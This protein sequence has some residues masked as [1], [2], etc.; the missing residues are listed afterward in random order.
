MSSAEGENKS[1]VRVCV[2]ASGERETGN[3]QLGLVDCLG[4]DLTGGEARVRGRARLFGRSTSPRSGPTQFIVQSSILRPTDDRSRQTVRPPNT[5]PPGSSY[6]LPARW[7]RVQPGTS[8]PARNWTGSTRP[9]SRPNPSHPLHAQPN[10]KRT[11]TELTRPY[12]SQSKDGLR[13]RQCLA[14]P[15]PTEQVGITTS[16]PLIPAR[17]NQH[18]G[19]ELGVTG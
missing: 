18:A 6:S 1:R 14:P 3:W 11:T 12:S 17:F 4:F 2:T 5:P 13:S 15:R 9:A 10:G 16:H 8:E 7:N 19:L